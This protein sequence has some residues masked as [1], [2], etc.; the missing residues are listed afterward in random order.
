[1][2]DSEPTPQ[3]TR[4]LKKGSMTPAHKAALELGRKRSRAV[5][6][7]LEAIE[8]HAP[9]RGPKRTLEKVR[10][11][12]AQVA[13]E[14]VTADT[15]RRLD[16]VQNR[17]S[18]QKEVADMEPGVD[19]TALEAEFVAHAKDYGDSKSPKIS[20]EAWRA[21]GVSARVLKAAGITEAPTD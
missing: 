2:S 21:M 3:K 1:M 4:G 15:L 7:Y 18:L 16:L 17:I 20:Y 8:K 12:L 11:E 13:N 5:R 9:K 19:M 14:M 6:A 10:R